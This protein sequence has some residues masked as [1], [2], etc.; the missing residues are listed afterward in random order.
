MHE[1]K[2]IQ[3]LYEDLLKRAEENGATKVTKAYLSMG[4]FTEI[5][6]EILQFFFKIVNM[7]CIS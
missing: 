7:M 2:F 4:D 5:N 6:E 3:T 1:M